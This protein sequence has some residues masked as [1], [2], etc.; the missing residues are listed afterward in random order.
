MTDFD[1]CEVP[2]QQAGETSTQARGSYDDEMG[3]YR[4]R[5]AYAEQHHQAG[6]EPR[7]ITAMDPFNSWTAQ[8]I[9][10]KVT[11]L[12]TGAMHDVAQE[13]G[14]IGADLHNS[15]FTMGQDAKAAIEGQWTGTAA[16]AALAGISAHAADANR[17]G[18]DFDM[19]KIK[20]ETTAT[21]IDA[22]KPAIPNPALLGPAPD[23]LALAGLGLKQWN[24]AQ[25]EATI[26]ARMAMNS[27]YAPAMY[28]ADISVPKIAQPTDP[29]DGPPASAPA[30]FGGGGATGG[31]LGGPLPG[32]VGGGGGGQAP[33]GGGAAGGQ[34]PMSGDGSAVG[35]VP[36][37]PGAGSGD[38]TASAT[39]SPFG[40]P[41][42]SGSFGQPASTASAGLSPVSPDGFGAGGTGLG[43]SGMGGSGFGGAG[44]GG[45]SVG[46]FGSIGGGGGLGGVSGGFGGAMM[47]PLSGSGGS[48]SVGGGAGRV[49]VVGES[50]V[51]GVGT[52]PARGATKSSTTAMP[53]GARSGGGDDDEEY[54]P[55]TYLVSID[56]GNKLIGELPMVVPPVIGG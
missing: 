7:A 8:Q 29:V 35:S 16:E 52:A 55:A 4:A 54:R 25:Q 23:P 37:S 50:A 1:V 41:S 6:F 26:E 51:S 14:S 36:G 40:S 20:A 31:S 42:D 39:G 3:Q 13:W 24:T 46:G 56:N 45:G 21:A 48:G 30:A 34:S 2:K 22:T 17:L 18:D 9:Y 19:I 53:H 49:G 47:P 12:Q 43:G 28:E 38:A 32:V 33:D 11:V 10:D 27:V 15:V 44:G 5:Q